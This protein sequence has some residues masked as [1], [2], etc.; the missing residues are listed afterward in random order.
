M[1]VMIFMAAQQYDISNKQLNA[2]LFR[3]AYTLSDLTTPGYE[4][5]TFNPTSFTPDGNTFT[6]SIAVTAGGTLVLSV[7]DNASPANK[8]DL[9]GAT[10]TRVSDS[11]G[12]TEY[13]AITSDCFTVGTGENTNQVTVRYL[14]YNATDASVNVFIKIVLADYGTKIFEVRMDNENTTA[15]VTFDAMSNVTLTF[16]DA[17]WTNA[18]PATDAEITLTD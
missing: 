5:A 9:T 1:D 16:A 7:T 14:P 2:K 12:T 8:L 17:N 6:D 11:T 15:T 10:I 13:A 18:F 3:K 4:T